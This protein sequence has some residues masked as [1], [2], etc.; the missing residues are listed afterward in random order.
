MS[1]PGERAV[2]ELLPVKNA[3]HYASERG[4]LSMVRQLLDHKP[5]LIDTVDSINFTA[6]HFASQWLT[7]SD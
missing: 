1:S 2:V 5:E 7:R 6:L 4:N 3:L